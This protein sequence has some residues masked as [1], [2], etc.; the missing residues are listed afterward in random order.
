MRQLCIS[1]CWTW[2]AVDNLHMFNSN[3]AVLRAVVCS[4]S[5][6][7]VAHDVLPPT[8]FSHPLSAPQTHNTKTT[9][10]E[11]KRE[12]DREREREQASERNERIK[13]REKS[14]KC[15]REIEKRQRKG[16][17]EH[18]RKRGRK[19]EVKESKKERENASVRNGTRILE[20]MRVGRN[21]VL[22]RRC[23]S[24][25]NVSQ[26]AVL[27]RVDRKREREKR[28]GKKER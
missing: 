7:Q 22:V 26:A 21:E 1:E 6:F 12:K 11:R 28:K 23:D 13:Q 18:E 24:C 14:E 20:R 3:C 27:E 4:V 16:E 2:R 5:M 19:T 9:E 25:T 15:K 10:E 8:F 17:K